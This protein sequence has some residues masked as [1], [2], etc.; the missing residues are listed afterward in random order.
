[1]FKAL[2]NLFKQ[3]SEDSTSSNIADE[4]AFELSMAALLCEVA[5][6][7]SETNEEES[8]AK[9]HQ[10]SLLLNIDTDRASTL[11]ATAKKNSEEAVSIYEFTSKLR[12]VE[13][14]Q[15][16]VLIES[17]W[18]VAYADGIIDPYEEALIRQVADLIYITHSDY[19]KAKLAACV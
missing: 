12:N 6:A 18:H 3:I 7:D 13:Y 5:S 15:R 16:Y 19:I 14:K 8:I 4:Q 10:L 1:M 17:M 2:H 9:T 11:L